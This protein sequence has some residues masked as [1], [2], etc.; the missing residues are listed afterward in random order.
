VTD[1][2]LAFEDP[3]HPGNGPKY[4][5]G[6]QCYVHG[7]TNPAGT[8][9]SPYWCFEHNV[10]RIRCV[11]KQLSDIVAGHRKREEA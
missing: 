1:A 5:T 2:L 7:C 11:D 3:N 10:E 8:A 4:H 9:W 6:K